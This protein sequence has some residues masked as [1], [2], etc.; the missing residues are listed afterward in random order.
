MALSYTKQNQRIIKEYRLAGGAWPATKYDIAE[1]AL[2]NR[3]WELSPEDKLRACAEAMATAM[4][5]E[6]MTDETGRR[7]RL[8]HPAK[9]RMGGRPGTFWGDIR[10]GDRSHM[11]LSVATKRRGIVAECLQMHNDVQWF[12]RNNP[13]LEAIQLHLDFTQDVAELDQPKGGKAA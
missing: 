8:K 4:S 12:N 5:Q 10:D 13:H 11:E 7:V 1:W 6:Y 2:A 3:K 9:M